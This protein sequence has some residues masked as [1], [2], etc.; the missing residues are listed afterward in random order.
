MI[1]I[2]KIILSKLYKG[3]VLVNIV[4]LPFKEETPQF[5]NIR[6]LARSPFLRTSS[7]ATTATLYA[8]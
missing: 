6:E 4:S 7:F 5:P 1:N 2:V 3:L 8:I